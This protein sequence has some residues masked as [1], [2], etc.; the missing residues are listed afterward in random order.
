MTDSVLLIWPEYFLCLIFKHKYHIMAV[1]P[2][3]HNVIFNFFL[4]STIFLSICFDKLDSM[5]L[6]NKILS[7]ETDIKCFSVVSILI[8]KKTD[9]LLSD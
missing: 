5:E 8:L 4:S 1:N 7:A 2:F 3:C 9:A 6:E